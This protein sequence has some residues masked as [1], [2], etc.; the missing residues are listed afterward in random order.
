[1]PSVDIRDVIPGAIGFAQGEQS[2][3]GVQG[4]S[5][6]AKAFNNPNAFSLGPNAVTNQ[7]GPFREFQGEYNIVTK[8]TF[9][10]RGGT[11]R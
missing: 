7:T 8:E 11:V 5:I 1:M 3:A 2:V 9:L 10:P 4:I 6:L